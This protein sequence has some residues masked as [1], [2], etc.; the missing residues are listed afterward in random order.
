VRDAPRTYSH[1]LSSH[2]V[3]PIHTPRHTSL[4]T[5]PPRSPAVFVHRGTY[6]LWTSGTRGWE[7]A[8]PFLYS[9]SSPLG[10]F[11]A[12]SNPGHGWHSYLKSNLE[13]EQKTSASAAMHTATA[14]VA[15]WEV[16][17]GYLPQGH[18]YGNVS[19]VNTTLPRA[20]ALCAGAAACVGFCFEDWDRRPPDHRPIAVAFKTSATFVPENPAAGIQPAPIPRPGRAGNARPAQPGVNAFDSQS[21]YILPN[22]QYAALP[23]LTLTVHARSTPSVRSSHRGTCTLC[24]AGTVPVR[25]SR[26]SCTWP[27]GG[28]T[29]PAPSASRAP[30]MSGCRSS[31]TTPTRAA[32]R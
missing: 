19:K 29:R 11:A 18:V 31:S 21:T 2:T 15:G 8:D 9:A 27:I 14:A 6:Y 1:L 32:S 3:P 10:D 22:P 16:R 7:P 26:S 23:R 30:H 12:S 24:A 17:D 25:S 4:H 5:L 20:L 13:A 28:T